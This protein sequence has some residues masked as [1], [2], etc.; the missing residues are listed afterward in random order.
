[1]KETQVQL[2]RDY[3]LKVKI[4]KKAWTKRREGLRKSINCCKD[5]KLKHGNVNGKN[6]PKTESAKEQ[7]PLQWKRDSELRTQKS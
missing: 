3:F 4:A 5:N 2:K 1:M 7:N 6:K